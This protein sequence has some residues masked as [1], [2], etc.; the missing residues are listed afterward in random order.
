MIRIRAHIQ[1]EQLAVQQTAQR[2][3]HGVEQPVVHLQHPQTGD[4]LRQFNDRADSSSR[5]Y[6]LPEAQSLPPLKKRQRKQISHR[7]AQAE[8]EEDA[9]QDLRG[10]QA[11]SRA[12]SHLKRA[13][14]T[15]ERLQPVR[16]HVRRGS[17][18][19]RGI[20]QQEDVSHADRPENGGKAGLP[21]RPPQEDKRRSCDKQHQQRAK[22]TAVGD[23]G[24]QCDPPSIQQCSILIK[25]HAT[26]YLIHFSEFLFDILNTSFCC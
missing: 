19:K 10:F 18:K 7:H 8:V 22:E 2:C 9:F 24:K 14:Q 17:G 12:F 23:Q 25:K 6:H 20:E 5:A 13:F 26:Y 4:K 21:I 1:R 16:P 11:Q 15:G 3:A